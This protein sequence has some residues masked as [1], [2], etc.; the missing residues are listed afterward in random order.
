MALTIDLVRG[1]DD[2]WNRSLGV[3]VEDPARHGTFGAV[4]A[5]AASVGLTPFRRE[6][7]RHW[8]DTR[9]DIG[10]LAMRRTRLPV[11]AAVRGSRQVVRKL[12]PWK[13]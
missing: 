12:L 4:I 5:E 10:L 2:L 9:V 7:V 8:G 13:R 6:V 3:E 1:R 11:A